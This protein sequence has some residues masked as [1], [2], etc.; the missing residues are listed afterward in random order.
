MPVTV[1]VPP[2]WRKYLDD[3]R[4][5][6]VAG[7]T[8]G[9]V[10]SN[11]AAEFPSLKKRIYGG[12]GRLVSALAVFVNQDSIG[13]MAGLETPVADGDRVTILMAIAGG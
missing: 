1:R 9:E 7:A 13:R 11:L 8:V 4:E 2:P 10:V 12:D 3:R 5:V 6:D